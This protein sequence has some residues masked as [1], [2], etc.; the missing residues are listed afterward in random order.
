[1]KTHNA[2]IYHCLLCGK[3]VHREPDLE[4]PECCG[5]KMVKAAA[6]TLFGD[7]DAAVPPA[8][9]K[10]AATPPNSSKPR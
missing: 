3:V 4:Q 8:P 2:I 9:A 5:Q 1:M 10:P 7:E 6:E